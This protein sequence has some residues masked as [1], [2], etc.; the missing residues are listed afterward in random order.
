[1]EEEYENQVSWRTSADKLTFIVCK[2]LD[3]ATTS[4]PDGRVIAGEAD[5]DERMIGD[6]NLFLTPWDDEDEEG[7]GDQPSAQSAANGPS[8]SHC[9]GEVDIMIANIDHRG[10]G[11]GKAAVAAYLWFIKRNVKEILAEYATSTGEKG[12]LEMKELLVRIKAT[13]EGS[14]ALFKGLGFRQRGEVNYFGEI[15]MVLSESGSLEGVNQVEGYKE[16]PFDRSRL[17]KELGYRES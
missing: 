16:L 4:A 12:S 15:A 9:V 5:S 3:A 1:M 13:N 2:P 10:K 6:I 7:G 17:A 8:H 11:T 14:I